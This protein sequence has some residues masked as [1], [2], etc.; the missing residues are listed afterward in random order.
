MLPKKKKKKKTKT[1][2]NPAR[3]RVSMAASK[4]NKSLESI[5]RVNYTATGAESFDF[6]ATWENDDPQNPLGFSP[7]RKAWLLSQMTFL[8]TV[9]S[10]GS[11]VPVPAGADIAASFGVSEELAVLVVALYMLGWAFGPILW[12]PVG[13]VYGR[14]AS[15]LPPVFVM[16][17]FSIGS[18]FSPNLSILLVSE[19]KSTPNPSC[20]THLG[21]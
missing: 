6:R 4:S 12:A 2:K 10:F 1:K 18:A 11:S 5:V 21:S 13:E 16:G 17:L 3:H 8:A 19:S 7:G 20:V 14:K 15:V 9:S